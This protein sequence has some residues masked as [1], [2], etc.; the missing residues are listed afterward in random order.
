MNNYKQCYICGDSILIGTT[1][2]NCWQKE[3]ARKK[4]LE[5][6]PKL[7]PRSFKI[8]PNINEYTYFVEYDYNSKK[9]AVSLVGPQNKEDQTLFKW[10]NNFSWSY[11]GNVADS[12]RARVAELGGR[13]D[14]VLRFTHSWN[15]PEAGRNASLMDLHVFLPGSTMH[16]DECHDRYPSGQRVGWNNRVDHTSGG[17]QDVDYTAAAPE[18]YIPIE[19]I[20][21]PDM[22]KLR[23]GKYVFKIHNWQLREPTKSGFRAEIEF[24]GQI[25]HYNHPA[26]LKN[27]QWITLAEVTLKNGVFTIEHKMESKTSSQTKWNI[28]T[29]KWHNVKAITFSPN[30]WN[31]EIGN[32]HHMFFL[33]GCKSD[34]TTRAFYNEFLKEDLAKDRKVFELLGNRVKV[35]PVEN[36]LSGLGFSDTIRNEMIVE[37]TGNI[38]RLLKIKF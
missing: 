4:E 34:D 18:N 13:V 19:N 32:K 26:P 24:G 11:T 5:N 16:G 9:W 29:E 23:D 6:R 20:A 8:E 3:Q 10:N 12:M 35:E 28:G 27:K 22:K 36:E 30:Y 33:E 38:K 2:D 31:S 1:C 7:I 17:K 25:F 15:H 14:G 21:F 37:V